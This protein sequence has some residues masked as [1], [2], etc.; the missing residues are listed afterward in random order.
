MVNEIVRNAGTPEHVLVDTDYEN[1]IQI[2]EVEASTGITG[3]LPPR[4]SDDVTASEAETVAS[5][6]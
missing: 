4:R 6:Q 5:D 1:V 3:P 2:M